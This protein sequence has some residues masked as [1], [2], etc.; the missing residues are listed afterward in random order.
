[1][2]G[3]AVY[4][5]SL[6]DGGRGRALRNDNVASEIFPWVGWLQCGNRCDSGGDRLAHLELGSLGKDV[7]KQVA[8]RN[9]VQIDARD[10]A[11]AVVPV[12][13]KP[14]QEC[15]RLDGAQQLAEIAS[16]AHGLRLDQ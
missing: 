4:P 14:M 12:A 15:V 3:A 11:P 10:D 8:H 5:Q 16:Q 13:M 6:S 1:M 9:V 2:R 7:G